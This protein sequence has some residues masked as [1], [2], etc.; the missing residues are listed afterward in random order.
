MILISL[1]TKLMARPTNPASSNPI[2][3]QPPSNARKT[4]AQRLRT[5]RIPGLTEVKSWSQKTTSLVSSD[6]KRPI[7]RVGFVVLPLFLAVWLASSIYGFFAGLFN[8]PQITTP[9]AASQSVKVTKPTTTAKDS[10][11]L[12]SCDGISGKMQTAKVSNK[13]VNKIFWEKHPEQRNQPINAGNKDL[14]Q[15]WCQIAESLA[16]R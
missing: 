8:R 6:F 4:S 14:T 9:Q 15:E 1:I 3:T 12:S 5:L 11:N 2:P 7:K 13:Q 10:N 16:K